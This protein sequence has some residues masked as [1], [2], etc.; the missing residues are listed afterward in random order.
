MVERPH[1]VLAL[2]VE[3]HRLDQVIEAGDRPSSIPAPDPVPRIFEGL[4]D[5]V[6]PAACKER[7][8]GRSR[9]RPDVYVT[10]VSAGACGVSRDGIDSRMVQQRLG[11][12]GSRRGWRAGAEP[13]R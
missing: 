2:I 11:P 12:V 9:A 3:R 6:R 4:R 8:Q 13:S 5:F 10:A 7:V 1:P